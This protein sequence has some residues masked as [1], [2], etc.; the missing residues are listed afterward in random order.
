[1]NPVVRGIV[2]YPVTPF[3]PGD[4]EVVDVAVLHLLIDRMI[5]AGV[6]AVAPLGSAGEGVYLDRGEW[7]AV[8]R[9]SV[10]YVAGRVPTVVGVSDLT[11]AGAVHRARI[12]EDVGATAVMALPMSYWRLTETELRRHFTAIADAISI[13]VMVYNNPA[14][15]GIDMSPEFLADL[16]GTVDGITMVKESSGDITRMHRLRDLGGGE[17]PFFNGRNP[18]ALQAFAAG[19][20]GWCTVAPCLIPRQI[21]EFRRLVDAGESAA[22]AAVF[23]RIRPVLDAIV[24][25]GLPTTVKSGL[26]SIGIDAGEP[27]PP[28]LPLED[29]AA[30]E[31]RRR[32][33]AA[34]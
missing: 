20:V 6:D 31:L 5:E 24:G 16:V 27:R 29:A 19:A 4:T 17:L 21:V 18:L 1:M 2:A 22:A 34:L 26:R 14:T 3:R 9:E 7:D 30:G 10:E 23:R 32:I 15:T 13:P 25:R 33:V 11:T 12:A 28:M 8:A